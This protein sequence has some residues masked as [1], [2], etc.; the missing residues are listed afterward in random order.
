MAVLRLFAMILAFLALAYACLWLYLRAA[1]KER[2]AAEWRA[3]RPPLPEHRFVSNGLEA[4]APGLR[5][6]LAL[7]VF[8]LPL[9]AFAALIAWTELV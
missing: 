9:G 5:M 2:L 6:R 3:N 7:W 4:A 8:A 1:H